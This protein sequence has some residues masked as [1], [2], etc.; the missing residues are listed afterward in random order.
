LSGD[1][2]LVADAIGLEGNLPRNKVAGFQIV[3]VPEPGTAVLLVLGAV[4]GLAV[5]RRRG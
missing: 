4:V 3:M 1:F 2:T 5:R